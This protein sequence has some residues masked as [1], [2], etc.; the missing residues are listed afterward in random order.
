MK[1]LMFSLMV[2][3][4]IALVSCS[5]GPSDE[6]VKQMQEDAAAAV[7][8]MFGDEEESLEETAEEAEQSVMDAVEDKA[9]EKTEE[10]KEAAKDAIEEL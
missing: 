6:E 8:E 1:K 5:S 7:D 10:A 9:V 2:F 4:G 3:A